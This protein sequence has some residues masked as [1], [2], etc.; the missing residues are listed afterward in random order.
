MATP[1]HKE[2]MKQLIKTSRERALMAAFLGKDDDEKRLTLQLRLCCVVAE[3]KLSICAV[4]SLVSVLK[5]SF[6]D[7]PILSKLKLGKQKC[8]NMIRFG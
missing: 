7:H 5:N 3:K 1:K 2:A 8:G 6:P 4:E